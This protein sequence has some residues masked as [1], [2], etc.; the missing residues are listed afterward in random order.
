MFH[1]DLICCFEDFTA[2][3]QHGCEASRHVHNTGSCSE[4]CTDGSFRIYKK[5]ASWSV[6][7]ERNCHPEITWVPIEGHDY[8]MYVCMESCWQQCSLT[9][10]SSLTLATGFSTIKRAVV[11][12]LS[13]LRCLKQGMHAEMVDACMLDHAESPTLV[14]LGPMYSMRRTT[15]LPIL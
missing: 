7:N 4:D 14:S 1:G 2:A 8:V 9:R 12:M 11:N 13:R 6:K 5:H 3:S 15:S 10:H